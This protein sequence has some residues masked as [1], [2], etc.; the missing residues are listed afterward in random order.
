MTTNQ[1]FLVS[2]I[3]SILACA[4]MLLSTFNVFTKKPTATIP[5]GS[6]EDELPLDLSIFFNDKL[7][8][9]STLALGIF[10][11]LIFVFRFWDTAVLSSSTLDNQTSWGQIILVVYVSYMI[12]SAINFSKRRTIVRAGEV[13]SRNVLGR[14]VAVTKKKGWQPLLLGLHS[15][16]L[17][18]GTLIEDPD[19]S[20]IPKELLERLTKE[21]SIP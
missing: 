16:T 20:K 13:A 10:L 3:L 17:D 8:D 2:L 21:M 6:D 15:L 4:A 18:I 5:D 11:P 9:M 19:D 7:L 14:P 1:L 12:L